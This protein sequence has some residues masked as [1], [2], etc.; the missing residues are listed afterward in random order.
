[1]LLLVIDGLGIGATPDAPENAREADTVG[2]V[3]PAAKE[4]AYPTFQALGLFAVRRRKPHPAATWTSPGYPGADSFAGHSALVGQRPR[5]VV[6]ATLAHWRDAVARALAQEGHRVRRTKGALEVDDAILVYD[7]LEAD[8]GQA[9]SVAGPLAVGEDRLKQVGK[10]VRALVGTPRVIVYG[11]PGRR[12]SPA[13]LVRRADGRVGVEGPTAGLYAEGR[14]V[15]H[16]GPPADP[17]VGIIPEVLAQGGRVAVVGKGASFLHPDLHCDRRPVSGAEAVI[18]AVEDAWADPRTRLVVATVEETD[19]AGHA[20]DVRGFA[21]VMQRL[22]GWL[23]N[24]WERAGAAE[25]TVITGDHGNDPA[26]GRGHTREYLPVMGWGLDWGPEPLSG[27]EAVGRRLS[28]LLGASSRRAGTSD[29]GKE[30]LR[31]P[32][33]PPPGDGTARSR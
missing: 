30:A 21:A 31:R 29:D 20:G 12:L 1:V 2:R 19:L 14:K 26:L 3:I 18:R 24:R 9:V 28:E 8:V 10:Q 11:L 15:W 5:H 16:L 6:A 23:R 13:L 27:L 32:N 4:A 22:D 7:N 25:A 17:R 33:E